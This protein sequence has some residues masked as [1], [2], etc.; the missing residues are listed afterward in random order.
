ML[1]MSNCITIKPVYRLV[2][3]LFIRVSTG[4]KFYKGNIMNET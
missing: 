2:I 1:V 3:L 4:M